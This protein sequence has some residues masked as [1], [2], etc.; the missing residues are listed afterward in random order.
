[1]QTIENTSWSDIKSEVKIL[2]KI[3]FDVI[4]DNPELTPESLQIYK[5]QFGE[6]VGDHKYFYSPES[7]A[8]KNTIVP[9]TMVLD[10]YFEMHINLSSTELP[11]KIYKPGDIF[12]YSRFL[13]INNYYEPRNILTMTSGVKNGFFLINK[14]A[15]KK[16]HSSLCK[17]NNIDTPPPKT[18][19]AHHD[20]FKALASSSNN[21]W[22][23]KLLIFPETFIKKA[24]KNHDFREMI[25]NVSSLD[26]IFKKN[27]KAY[28]LF[29][30]QLFIEDKYTSSSFVRDS[31]K[32]L[33]YLSCGDV[34]GYFPTLNSQYAPIQLLMDAYINDF[35][36]KSCPIFMA[37]DFLKPFTSL[38]TAYYSLSKPD[39][40][41]KRDNIS[42]QAKVT[43]TI[44]DGFN[45]IINKVVDSNFSTN[46]VFAMASNFS[47][48]KSFYKSHSNPNTMNDNNI[49][50]INFIDICKKYNLPFPENST[51]LNNCFSIA[52]KQHYKI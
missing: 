35:K 22:L 13:T 27:I 23:G 5:Y 16:S 12:P 52:Y 30:H 3:L 8:T 50:D 36:S 4:E 1:M 49:E 26:H 48:I 37:P 24:K 29:L 10:K 41:F 40:L 17:K 7:T 19:S 18:F 9:F 11:W 31:I 45:S 20:V 34:P 38:N 14:I 28:E 2:N 15:D 51:F 33:L 43:K 25:F 39:Y 46:T 44:E 21:K 32:H 42:S 47:K 6:V